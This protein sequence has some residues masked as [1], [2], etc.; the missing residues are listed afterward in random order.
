MAQAEVRGQGDVLR[1]AD[2]E[3]LGAQRVEAELADAAPT[4]GRPFS[5]RLA[6]MIRHSTWSIATGSVAKKRALYSQ[7]HSGFEA[8]RPALVDPLDPVHDLE[9]ALLADDRVADDLGDELVA[10]VGVGRAVRPATLLTEPWL[11]F[12]SAPVTPG[13]AV[14]LEHRQHH[15]LVDPLRVTSLPR[16][17]RRLRSSL[18][19]SPWWTSSIVT[20]SSGS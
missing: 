2:V 20:N 8:E 11:M 6:S 17:E 5:L 18:G 4:G 19:S 3:A 12:L 15:D 16:C 13:R 14:V 7:V 1:L 10:D 9:D